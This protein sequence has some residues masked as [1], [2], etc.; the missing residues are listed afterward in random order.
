MDQ[1]LFLYLFQ[2]TLQSFVYWMFATLFIAL[3]SYV[4]FYMWDRDAANAYR[5]LWRKG[6][7][8]TFAAFVSFGFIVGEF[9][10]EA[11]WPLAGIAILV[12]VLDFG[13]LVTPGKERPVAIKEDAKNA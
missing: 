9:P 5:T 2:L 3:I 11:A 7:Y 6:Y 13:V 4:A 8:L 12:V 10:L 1:S